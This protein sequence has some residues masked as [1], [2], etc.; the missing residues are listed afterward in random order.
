MGD[1]SKRWMDQDRAGVADAGVGFLIE[2]G[3]MIRLSRGGSS[4]VVDNRC[5]SIIAGLGVADDLVRQEGHV[6][7]IV[8]WRQ[9]V[10]TRFDNDLVHAVLPLNSVT[11]TYK[12]YK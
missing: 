12:G 9:F 2:D 10:D 5:I 8:A 3:I 1:I 7:V 6:R 11:V 4:V